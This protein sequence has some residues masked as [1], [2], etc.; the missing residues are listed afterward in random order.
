MENEQTLIYKKDFLSG[1]LGLISLDLQME[2]TNCDSS[3]RVVDLNTP[4]DALLRA[5]YEYDRLINAKAHLK[6]LFELYKST[7]AYDRNKNLT[8]FQ[9]DRRKIG[10]K[11]SSIM[12][13]SDE[14][15]KLYEKYFNVA[16][17][18]AKILIDIEDP[19]FVKN[20]KKWKDLDI[21]DRVE[22]V[23]LFYYRLI[24]C[25]HLIFYCNELKSKMLDIVDPM[26][27]YFQKL[28]DVSE[29]E[30]F[31]QNCID[32]LE[33]QWAKIKQRSIRNHI[34]LLSEKIGDSSSPIYTTIQ[35][36]NS[37]KKSFKNEIRKWKAKAYQ[38]ELIEDSD[39]SS[40]STPIEGKETKLDLILV[41]DI[42]VSKCQMQ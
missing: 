19:D 14:I 2:C 20:P 7:K 38:M 40:I 24:T 33:N 17:K 31:V 36:H 26:I 21:E 8:E 1:K 18:Y 27:G 28:N 4:N 3:V 5:V 6:H 35:K 16:T 25:A 23:K 10:L 13:H 12:N 39:S 22:L 34:N 42:R 37:D 9:S 32:L 41:S 11:I 29:M 15:V 30:N